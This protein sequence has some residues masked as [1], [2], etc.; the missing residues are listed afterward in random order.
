MLATLFFSSG[1][2]MLLAGDEI[3]RTQNGNNNAYCQ[4]NELSWIDWSPLGTAEGHLLSDFV[5]RLTAAR[6]HYPLLRARRFLHGEVEVAEG[7]PDID[8]F[9]ERGVHL[10]EEDWNNADGRALVMRRARRRKDGALEVVTMLTN[11]ADVPLTFKLPP[12]PGL[13]RRVIIDSADPHATEY[14]VENEVVVQDRAVM[15]IVGTGDVD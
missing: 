10:S 3:G 15:L 7:I 1:T 14:E 4:D 2:P 9:D 5:R 6:R 11:A 8:W 12:P 13:E